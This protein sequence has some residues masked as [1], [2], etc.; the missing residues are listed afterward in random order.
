MGIE[1][2]VSLEP[3]IDTEQSIEIIHKTKDFVYE[4]GIGKI[5]AKKRKSDS[6]EMELLREIEKKT[7][8]VKFR[9]DAIKVCQRYGKEYYII[10]D[11]KYI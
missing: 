8:W 2:W 3:V 11:L 5:N 10:K 9:E 4:Y 6:S 1:T 7:D